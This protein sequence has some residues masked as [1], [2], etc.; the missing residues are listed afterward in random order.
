MKCSLKTN[1]RNLTSFMDA[2]FKDLC[3][4]GFIMTWETSDFLK[5]IYF[6]A[7]LRLSITKILTIM[8]VMKNEYVKA[9]RLLS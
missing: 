5:R 4:A 3:L 2:P 1:Q 8:V 9:L 7:K 6:I